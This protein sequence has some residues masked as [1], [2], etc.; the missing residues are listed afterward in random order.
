MDFTSIPPSL[1]L[2]TTLLPGAV[3]FALALL[4]VFLLPRTVEGA[5]T[6][7]LLA[8]GGGV[9]AV[10]GF[11]A[12]YFALNGWPALPP[13]ASWQWLPY[14]ALLGLG[15]V[16]LEALVPTRGFSGPGWMWRPAFAAIAVV[17]VF[18]AALQKGTLGEGYGA[19]PYVVYVL[20][21]AAIWP[22]E[23]AVGRGLHGVFLAGA[24]SAWVGVGS[25]LLLWSESAQLSQLAG[26]MSFA[27]GALLPGCLLARGKALPVGLPAFLTPWLAAICG[28]GY[29]LTDSTNVA[30][31]VLLG[32]APFALVPWPSAELEPG[33]RRNV[34]RGLALALYALAL[35]GALGFG[36][37]ES[38]KKQAAEPEWMNY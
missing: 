18:G 31:F 32:L 12:A 6:G 15:V 4:A 1:I 20:S 11:V 9:A 27:L 35:L 24:L 8:I 10:L 33:R 37:A 23:R 14:I 36:Y 17:A 38:V 5:K 26:A 22:W 3:S 30:G 19:L 25:L 7:G 13:P 29:W 2:K 28:V 34:L 16:V 21:V